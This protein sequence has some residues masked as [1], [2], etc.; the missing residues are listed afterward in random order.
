MA[1]AQVARGSD[2]RALPLT[3]AS[4]P[5]GESP[6]EASPGQPSPD[7]P[8]LL[9]FCSPFPGRAPHSPRVPSCL[10]ARQG[11]LTLSS[12]KLGCRAAWAGAGVCRT[13]RTPSRSSPIHSLFGVAILPGLGW[14]H[15]QRDR[16]E[17]GRPPGDPYLWA[18]LGLHPG[19]R[20]A[21]CR[22]VTRG[23]DR[24]VAASPPQ[25]CLC[26]RHRLGRPAPAPRPSWGAEAPHGGPL[27]QPRKAQPSSLVGGRGKGLGAALPLGSLVT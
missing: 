13:P 5:V 26:K 17:A 19:P 11:A 16:R 4:L 9:L 15:R 7:G 3:G 21:H 6:G 25:G 20:T 27:L 14:R 22:L 1:G 23:E 24:A 8:A 12:W 18:W 2:E 10:C